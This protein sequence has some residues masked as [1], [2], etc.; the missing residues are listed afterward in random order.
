[1]ALLFLWEVWAMYNVTLNHIKAFLRTRRI[2]GSADLPWRSV[3][4]SS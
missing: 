2:A 1:M 4:I 3:P